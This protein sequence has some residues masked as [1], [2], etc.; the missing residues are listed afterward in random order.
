MD[1]LNIQLLRSTIDLLYLT[2]LDDLQLA[3][4][5]G[6]AI[7]NIDNILVGLGEPSYADEV[8]VRM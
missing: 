2:Q 7:R 6:L 3:E 5:R 4:F 1:A 8:E